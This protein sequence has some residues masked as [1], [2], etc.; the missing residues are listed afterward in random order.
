VEAGRDAG[1]EVVAVWD[2]DGEVEVEEVR[3]G[4]GTLGGATGWREEVR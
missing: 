4:E 3:E 1:V 2:G